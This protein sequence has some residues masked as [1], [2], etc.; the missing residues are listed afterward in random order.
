MAEPPLH[1]CNV[2][3]VIKSIRGGGA[4]Q[5]VGADLKS[6]GQGVAAH[7]FVDAAGR[8]EATR[9]ALGKEGPPEKWM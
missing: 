3:L 8:Q 7:E 6:Q 9:G 2:G 1:L 4:A 5:C